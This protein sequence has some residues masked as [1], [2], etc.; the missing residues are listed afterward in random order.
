MNWEEMEPRV[1]TGT[2]KKKMKCKKSGQ[3]LGI[4]VRKGTERH[5]YV[6]CGV[7]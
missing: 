6:G 2:Y 1:T 7:Y 3:D 4:R 5:S